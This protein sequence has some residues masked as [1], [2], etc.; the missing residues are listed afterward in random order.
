MEK[1]TIVRI[2]SMSKVIS[3][4]AVMILH[5]EGRL[6]LDDQ[7]GKYLPALA[8]MKVFTGGS[9]RRPKLVDATRQMTVKDLLTH[10]SGLIYGFGHG[11]IDEIYRDAKT[12][13]VAVDGRLCRQGWR[14]CRWP[15]SPASGSA[16]A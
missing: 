5:E 3:S 2:Y 13:R 8:K 1:D 9:A 10:T 6:K 16:T 14:R 11:P 7:V 12:A 4:V 15:T